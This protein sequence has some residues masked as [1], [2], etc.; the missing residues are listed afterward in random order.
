MGDGSLLQY[1]ATELFTPAST[2]KILTALMALKTLGANFRFT[3]RLYLDTRN[4]L[5]IR[6]GGDPF[7]TSEAVL[8]ICQQFQ[9]KYPSIKKINA[10]F[11]DNSFY[12][13][14]G[15]QVSTEH[16]DNPYDAPNSALAVNFNALP[17]AVAANGNISSGEKQ[18]PLLP[19]MQQKAK[20][21]Q[22][23]SGK[24]RINIAY[25]AKDRE[26]AIL[27]YAAQLFAAQ[28]TTCG[29][30]VGKNIDAKKVPVGLP[31]ALIYQSEKNLTEMVRLLLLHSNNFIAN[32]IFLYLGARKSNT[33]LS[34]WITARQYTALFFKKTVPLPTSELTMVEG[35]G[36]S[37]DNTI[38]CR[39]FITAL[40]A[41]RPWAE[42]LPKKNKILLKSGTMPHSGVFSYAGYFISKKTQKLTPYAILLNQK[43]NTRNE[44]L[45]E[46][47][48]K[49]S[50]F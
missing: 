41:F 44:L 4:N 34:T 40:N 7:L 9:K 8:V 31:P 25:G 32:Q 20:Q 18:T 46:L 17:V 2:L 37:V 36:L 39:A 50:S 48:K 30:E 27:L 29:I 14:N 10:I 19:I 33:T 43:K 23:P 28:L 16:S 6:G 13:L 3:T 35:S 21:L 38:T 1:R 22:L 11:I 42:L 15:W 49:G 47:A 12:Q 24:Y 45:N 5:Y 26:A